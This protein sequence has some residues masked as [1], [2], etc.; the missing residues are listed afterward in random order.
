MKNTKDS[1][2]KKEL[3]NYLVN[4]FVKFAKDSR[5]SVMKSGIRME[6][7]TQQ[8]VAE[9]LFNLDK[10]SFNK[11][12]DKKNTGK[13]KALEPDQLSRGM[14][15]FFNEWKSTDNERKTA[16]REFIQSIDNKIRPYFPSTT[17]LYFD[18]LIDEKKR[19]SKSQS[20]SNGSYYFAG[21]GYILALQDLAYMFYEM[22]QNDREFV[23][24]MARRDRYRT[25]SID[26]KEYQATVNFL[27][28]PEPLPEYIQTY[29]RELDGQPAQDIL[30]NTLI[31][32]IQDDINEEVLFRI[33]TELYHFQT[34]LNKKIGRVSLKRDAF[35]LQSILREIKIRHLSSDEKLLDFDLNAPE[36]QP[37]LSHGIFREFAEKVYTHYESNYSSKHITLEDLSAK[38]LLRF[39]KDYDKLFTDHSV[40]NLIRFLEESVE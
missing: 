4:E 35:L 27:N 16:V 22:S 21:K 39:I 17:L 11:K 9:Y 1:I 40:N 30:Y 8:A 12:L 23:E 10:S 5:L 25:Y 20:E 34:L 28:N 26:D 24:L 37:D 2:E 38:A 29:F 32:S 3:Y 6:L 7:S 18:W 14:I 13:Y 31:H 15:M 36:L 19:I 33:A